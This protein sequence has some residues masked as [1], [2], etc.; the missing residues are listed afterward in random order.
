MV[1][2]VSLSTKI[3]FFSS[4]A[5]K[6]LTAQS[7]RSQARPGPQTQLS[8]THHLSALSVRG[9]PIAWKVGGLWGRGNRRAA[10]SFA[11]AGILQRATGSAGVVRRGFAC[12]PRPRP[13]VRG[14]SWRK[15]RGCT[16][17]S[18]RLR[19][20]WL[21]GTFLPPWITLRADP[22]RVEQLATWSGC[23]LWLT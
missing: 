6:Y 11:A 7:V 14:V 9:C 1:S 8:T 20:A 10:A 4:G 17:R 22:Q 12:A 15:R 23:I 21:W 3:P 13:S 18:V 16:S 5:L 19:C 2:L